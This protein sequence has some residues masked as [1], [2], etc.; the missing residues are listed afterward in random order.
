MITLDVNWS[1]GP[2]KTH[3]L[4]ERI[5]KKKRPM[6][7]LS[8]RDPLYTLEH[9]HTKSERMDK[10]IPHKWKSKESQSSVFKV[11]TEHSPG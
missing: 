2:S 6:C 1:N 4:V 3:G 11:N 8:R 5:Q 9:I 7:M 10:D